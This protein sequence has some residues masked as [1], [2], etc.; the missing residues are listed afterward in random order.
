MAYPPHFMPFPPV[1]PNPALERYADRVW[2]WIDQAGIADGEDTRRVLRRANPELTTARYFPTASPGLFV[3]LSELMAWI[4][5]NDDEFDDG[6]LG[7]DAASC[8]AAVTGRAGV[9]DGS[10]PSDVMERSLADLWSRLPQG[11]S[12]GWHATLRHDL[13][14]FLHSYAVESAERQS[15][16]PPDLGPYLAHRRDTAGT[17]W[18]TDLTEVVVGVDLPESVRRQAAYQAIKDAAAEHCGLFNDIHSAGKEAVTGQIHNAVCLVM[19]DRGLAL[20]E[21]MQLVN[22]MATDCVHAFEQAVAALP[23]SA[24]LDRWVTGVRQLVRG[25]VDWHFESERYRSD[26]SRLGGKNT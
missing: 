19:R 12:P 22:D 11:R 24:E 6:H 2:T 3:Y 26:L 21:A 8:R 16:R 1:P 23:R 7:R 25:N 9:L 15:G 13:K 20:E 17:R 4:F 5:V 18:C 14:A 10:V